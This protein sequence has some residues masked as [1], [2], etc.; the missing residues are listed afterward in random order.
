[1][2]SLR[3]MLARVLLKRR[4]AN[5]IDISVTLVRSR[6][7]ENATTERVSIR[8]TDDVEIR[9]D[10]EQVA[11]LNYSDGCIYLTLHLNK[12]RQPCPF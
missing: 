2:A 5:Y 10:T 8:S 9:S 6:D 11:S 12:P 1:M 7:Y 4:E 3:N